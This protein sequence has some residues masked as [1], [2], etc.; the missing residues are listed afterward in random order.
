MP[1]ANLMMNL[2]SEGIVRL[3]PFKIERCS[4]FLEK[5]QSSFYS[6]KWKKQGPWAGHNKL[7]RI[8][9]SPQMMRSRGRGQQSKNLTHKRALS[10]ERRTLD[11]SI[12]WHGGRAGCIQNITPV[13]LLPCWLE[14]DNRK[15]S[16]VAVGDMRT[17]ARRRC[18]AFAVIETGTS[19][20]SVLL[21]T[22]C[23]FFF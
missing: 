13:F 2:S 9:Q 18:Q 14:H 23:F 11:H 20:S 4:D 15:N 19:N 12:V 1:D 3:K 6:L 17:W 22:V 16:G 10:E 5:T 7:S 21:F 8:N